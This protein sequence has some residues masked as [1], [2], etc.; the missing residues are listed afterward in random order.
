MPEIRIN[1]R[2]FPVVVVTFP[3]GFAE[4][5]LDKL[6]EQLFAFGKRGA[7]Y[8][9]LV[10]MS[11]SDPMQMPATLRAHAAELEK[12]YIARYAST[13]AAEAYVVQSALTRGMLTAFH[14][15]R[16]AAP[17]PVK[18]FSDV[19]TARCWLLDQAEKAGLNR[20]AR[21]AGG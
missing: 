4:A 19:V 10:D 5:Q 12:T 20:Q 15:L 11:E 13:V 3:A 8:V 6:Y 1:D 17:W 7:R 18:F 21:V 2:D 16:G 14:W 9:Q